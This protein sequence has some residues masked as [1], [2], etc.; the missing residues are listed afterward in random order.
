MVEAVTGWLGENAPTD[1][2]AK[3]SPEP[4]LKNKSRLFTENNLVLGEDTPPQNKNTERARKT[5]PRLQSRNLS[6][7]RTNKAVNPTE[8]LRR[9]FRHRQLAECV[10]RLGLPP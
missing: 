8:N 1:S 2:V 4:K 10:R 6:S 7:E 9:S 3:L 5:G